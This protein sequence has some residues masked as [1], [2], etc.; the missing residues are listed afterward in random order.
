MAFLQ[1]KNA[2]IAVLSYILGTDSNGKT[3]RMAVIDSE[4]DVD[5]FFRAENGGG[6]R[7]VPA[8][9]A[10]EGMDK[11]NT[12]NPLVPSSIAGLLGKGSDIASAATI[13][14]VSDGNYSHVT[15]T[16]AI[17]DIDYAVGGRPFWVC[18]DDALTLTHNGTTLILP[19]G[20]NIL[21]AASDTA[22]IVL[23]SGDNVR[24]LQYNRNS[25]AYTA[26]SPSAGNVAINGAA[27]R[28]NISVAGSSALDFN[29]L[30]NLVTGMDYY[31][32]V[33]MTGGPYAITATGADR[34]FNFG[35]GVSVPS[36]KGAQLLI[37]DNGTQKTVT[38]CGYRD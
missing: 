2:T 17:T 9:L 8:A 4:A 10:A 34:T 36:G 16:V 23:E 30:T 11:T 15:G 38:F 31:V 14:L 6:T 20:Q 32:E 3:R 21:T 7:G 29:S 22:L 28:P 37:K 25:L 35:S 18:F 12:E 19:G 27:V 26:V 1:V 5:D 24:V 33:S 13:T